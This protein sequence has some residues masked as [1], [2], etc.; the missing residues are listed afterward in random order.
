MTNGEMDA[1]EAAYAVTQRC[2]AEHEAARAASEHL[3]AE[4][5]ATAQAAARLWRDLMTQHG[6]AKLK[7]EE[8][9]RAAVAAYRRAASARASLL[10]AKAEARAIYASRTR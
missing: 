1:I 5:D 2:E 8:A 7:A 10:K 9:E 6:A 3:R 4:A